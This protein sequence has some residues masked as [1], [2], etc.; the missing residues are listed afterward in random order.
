MRRW[1]LFCCLRDTG[2]LNKIPKDMLPYVETVL[3]VALNRLHVSKS[4]LTRLVHVSSSQRFKT[5]EFVSTMDAINVLYDVLS[6][7][8]RMKTKMVPSTLM[9]LIEVRCLSCLHICA[10]KCGDLTIFNYLYIDFTINRRSGGWPPFW[11]SCAPFPELAWRCLYF[12]AK[13][14]LAWRWYRP[15]IWGSWCDC[16]VASP[17]M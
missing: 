14:H 9:S 11:N 13:P 17:R 6:D 12:L 15:R 5:Q 2:I 8:F 4:S 3:R 16:Q 1:F 10:S 7:G